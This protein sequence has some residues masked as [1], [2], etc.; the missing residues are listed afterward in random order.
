MTSVNALVINAMTAEAEEADPKSKS[1]QKMMSQNV[2]FEGYH[3][4]EN[5]RQQSQSA[6]V[7]NSLAGQLHK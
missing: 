3:C 7:A 2:P 5:L 4:S 6:V 1:V